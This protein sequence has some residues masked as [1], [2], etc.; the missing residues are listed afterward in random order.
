MTIE[1]GH[2]ESAIAAL[3]EREYG[4][5]GDEYSRAGWAHLAA[6]RDGLSPFDAD[7]RGWVGVALRELLT[8]AIAYRVADQPERATRRCVE[9]VALARELKTALDR[10][11][12]RACLTEVVA[13]CRVVG[14]LEDA[15]GAY[16]DAEEAYLEA[17]GAVSDPERWATS[18]LFRAAAGPIKQVARGQADGEIAIGW[19]E[20]HG[21]DP[22][23]PGPFLARRATYKRQRFPALLERAVEDGYLAAPRGTTAYDTDHGCPRCGSADVNWVADSTLCLRCSTPTGRP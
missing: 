19:E 17:G 8:G 1:H 4:T 20:L 21:S 11:V 13:D 6:P 18:P 5:A 9:T 10:P 23:R 15:G 22:S 14:G 12:Q 2:R 3:A 7:E 16:R